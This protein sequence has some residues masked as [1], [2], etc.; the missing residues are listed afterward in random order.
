MSQSTTPKRQHLPAYEVLPAMKREA[1]YFLTRTPGQ[2]LVLALTG[3]MFVTLGA[4]FSLLLSDGV[5]TP[6]VALLMQGLGF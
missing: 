4:L 3:G 5:S 1:E 6:G 2:T